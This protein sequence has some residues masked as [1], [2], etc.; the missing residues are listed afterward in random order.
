MTPLTN[1]DQQPENV[2]ASERETPRQR[3]GEP[4]ETA[5]DPADRLDSSPVRPPKTPTRVG[6]YLLSRMKELGMTRQVDLVRASGVSDSTVSRLFLQEGYTSDRDTLVAL[7]GAL[8]VDP[9]DLVLFVFDLDNAPVSTHTPHPHAVQID[10]LLSP[11]THLPDED[12]DLLEAMVGRLIDS[13][14]KSTGRRRAG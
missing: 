8:R 11:G 2:D 10:Q 13:T 3:R 4:P 7:A 6:R 1:V 5:G 9:K 12:R 14:T